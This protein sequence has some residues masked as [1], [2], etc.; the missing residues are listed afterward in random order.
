MKYDFALFKKR[1]R[2]IAVII[3]KIDEEGQ[4]IRCIQR[5]KTSNLVEIYKNHN[6]TD[7]F[8]Y[9]SKTPEWSEKLE[10]H[11]LDF[12]G[13]A[14][15]PSVKNFILE[16]DEGKKDYVMFGKIKENVYGL[17]VSWPFSLYQAFALSIGSISF[18]IVCE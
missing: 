2:K 5:T 14:R 18:K 6:I 17:F 15:L 4:R 13:K 1:L 11:V 8:V 7:I 12:K 9:N 10:A 3:P 16:D